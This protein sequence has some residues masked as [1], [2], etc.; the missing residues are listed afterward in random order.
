MKTKLFL[1]LAFFVFQFSLA[2]ILSVSAP[3]T[4]N[5]PP[6][7]YCDTDNDGYGCFDLTTQSS[8]ILA[9]QT[10]NASDY[11]VS[12]HQTSADANMGFMPVGSNYCNITSL[13][14]VIYYRVREI[15]S[16]DFAVGTFN[17]VVNPRPIAVAPTDLSQC[18]YNNDGVEVFD[19]NPLISQI[20]G[21]MNPS[22]AT[23]TFHNTLTDAESGLSVITPI[24]SYPGTNGQTIYAR[25]TLNATGCYDVISFRLHVIPM[26][27]ILSSYPEYVLC[28]VTAPTGS[29]TFDLNS[30]ISSILMGQVGMAVTFYPSLSQAQSGDNAISSLQYTNT[31]NYTQT[32][33]IRITNVATG[34]YSVSTMDIRVEPLPQLIAPTAPYTVCDSDQDG[35]AV[36]DLT[37]LVPGLS[38]GSS[39]TISFHETQTDAEI[40]GTTIPNPSSYTNITPFS[41]TIYVRG[42]NNVSGCVAVLAIQLRVNQA[43]IAHA[44]TSIV[45]C[46]NDSNPQD[47]MAQFDLTQQTQAVL[48]LQSL[49]ASN[50]TITYHSTQVD[51]QSGF[52]PI[53]SPSN[54]TGS[55]G[56]VIWY[57]VEQNSTSCYNIAS[58]SIRVN[59]PLLLTTPSPFNVCDNDMVPNN[60]YTT[61]DLTV[62]D[63]EITEGSNQIV[64]YYPS[65]ALAQTGTN[66]ISNPTAYTNIA[67]SVQTLGVRV[68]SSGGCVSITTLDIRVM[69]IP[70]PNTNPPALASQCDS[71]NTGDMLEVFDLTAN[72]AYI[73]NG[74]PNLTL[75]YFATMANAENNVAEILTPTAAVVGSDVWIRVENT[76]TDSTGNHCYVLVR[77]PLTVNPLPSVDIISDNT[78]DTV[79][80]D[81][82][83]NNVI[84][85][86]TLDAQLDGN[87]DIQWK[88]DGNII[89]NAAS[90]VY[91][92]ATA[93]PNGASR[94]FTVTVTDVQ[95][96]CSATD[97]ITVLQSTGVPSPQGQISQSFN[98][99]GTLADLDVHGTNIAWYSS[100]NKNSYTTFSAPL[101]ANTLL[102]DGATYYASQT[103]GGMESIARLPVTVHLL[104]GIPDRET[105]LLQFAPNPVNSSLVLQSDKTLKSIE[106]YTMLGQKVLSLNC[107]D[108]NVT[109][110]F[111]G[112]SAG[113]Y[114][115][116]AQS[117]IGQKTIRLI[118]E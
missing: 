100:A 86:L 113:Y 73:I 30:R 63:Y 15:S 7:T 105:I 39:Y 46:D 45:V 51:A 6:L 116:K 68:T 25:L 23:V 9:A 17:L 10:G 28:D 34:C 98:A 76:R 58:F 97:S 55:D 20:L 49:P 21:V 61:F 54:F 41:Q 103:I 89:A 38:N 29:E 96:G 48:G 27:I 40:F 44:V 18:D 77:Q 47:G 81:G 11:E 52:S 42:V 102:V 110:D 12:Y 16:G 83:N 108:M 70:T 79:Y 115:L 107:N 5:V 114:L 26:P 71:N 67:P 95:T 111:A 104:L 19:F 75:H 3:V 13:N 118:K 117:D 1:G 62:K 50:Y 22:T 90:S 32:L 37:S 4:P 101:P 8:L 36:F 74:D 65:F 112:L 33:G 84:Q 66:P 91:T 80:V 56:Q 88:V 78:L 85:T 31:V 64:T 106:V 69:P 2:N 57:R 72:S 93:S 53:T 35:T 14:Q 92:V 60:Q 87:F 24:S 82:S 109:I 43:P 59:S 94:V 99:G